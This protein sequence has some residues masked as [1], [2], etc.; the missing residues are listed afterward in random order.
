MNGPP[1]YLKHFRL[2]RFP[3]R[4][5]ADPEVFFSQAGRDRIL[6]DLCADIIDGKSL[7][8][9]TGTEGTGKT[10]LSLLL[11]RKLKIKKFYVIC[12]ERPLGSFEELLRLML[13][14]LGQ[15]T[16]PAGE[17]AGA[18][19]NLPLLLTRLREKKAT[20]Q[21]VALLIDEA[22]QLFLAT[23]ERLVRLVAE[24]REEG[25]LSILLVGRPELDR[26]LEQLSGYCQHVD[27]QAGYFLAP[28]DL[29]ETESYLGFR[30][31]QAGCPVDKAK[32]IFSNEA[33]AA[34]YREARGN[35]SLIHLLAERGLARA[36]ES[37]M[38]QVNAELI[39]PRQGSLPRSTSAFGRLMAALLPRYRV[40]ALA[41]AVLALIL[42]L[43]AFW[44]EGEQ[45]VSLSSPELAA[46]MAEKQEP[47][48]EVART[49]RLTP[50]T[51][52]DRTAAPGT[53]ET[54][55]F[56]A[57]GEESS[58]P[59]V[60]VPPPPATEGEP[61]VAPTTSS[62]DAAEAIQA[63]GGNTAAVTSGPTPQSAAGQA[64]P[65]SAPARPAAP[66]KQIESLPEPVVFEQSTA[67]PVTMA[68]MSG[69]ESL[70]ATEKKIV[71]LQ[72]QARKRKVGVEPVSAVQPATKNGKEPLF[73]ERMRAS[74][75]WR[76]RSG[77]TIQIM[78]LASDTAEENFKGLLA[79]PQ[80]AAVKDQLYLVRKA[81]PPTLYIYYG[82]FATMEEARQGRDRLP[83]F[84]RKNQPYPLSIGQAAK[85]AND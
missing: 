34:L 77:Y 17:D 25:L 78:V 19:G 39:S 38:F 58:T 1:S 23:L 50:G 66:E 35:L 21:R 10:L 70:P 61:A 37:G 3:F 46:V 73:A 16:E 22:E 2:T 69:S 65:V 4:Q 75:R 79:Q 85:K 54:G 84:L 60:S 45:R 6:H 49:K 67:P 8:K 63:R 47:A 13:M 82:S 32:E 30:L 72:A 51:G 15:G 81:V 9:L 40:Q 18:G 7:L 48:S 53:G 76:A 27:M 71:V 83:D 68:E 74:N 36:Y 43:I 29:L 12:L 28:F 14:A 56:P 20:G 26:N 33:I 64:P 24:I 5:Q 41:G 62:A 80:Y 31:G 11:T 52:G 44:P 59:A 55:P 57:E 42:L